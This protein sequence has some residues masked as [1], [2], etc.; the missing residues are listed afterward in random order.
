[1]SS[2]RDARP[3]EQ[4]DLTGRDR[5][6]WN[7]LTSWACQL[8]F[9]VSGFVMPRMLDRHVGQATLGV[10]DLAWVVV[11]YFS[12]AQIGIGSSVNRYVARFRASGDVEGL[13]CAVSSAAA[14][15]SAAA[16]VVM[17]L[18]IATAAGVRAAG[19]PPATEHTDF[20]A[21]VL[22]LGG[23]LA[24]QML[25]DAY[26]GVITGCHRWDLHNALN[27]ASY[28]LITV[29]ML[30]AL[31]SGGGLPHLAAVNFVGTILTEAVRVR[32][33]YRVCPELSVGLRSV[34]IVQARH[35]LLFGAKSSLVW[36]ARLILIQAS[37]VLV[38]T[39]LGPATL[40][41]YARPLALVRHIE[42]LGQKFAFVLTPTAS[43]LDGQ[44]DSE[45][46]RRLLMDTGRYSTY[47]TLPA[48]L[49]LGILGGPIVEV[50]MGSG[51]SNDVLMAVL[52]VG[53]F[54]PL[55]QQPAVTILMGM[56]RHGTTA[57]AALAAAAT[58]T[59]LTWAL[60]ARFG[61]G[62]VGAAAGVATTL[63]A[64]GIFV[65]AYA[66][67]VLNVR[68]ARLYARTLVEP[69]AATAPYAAVLVIM[70]IMFGTRPL[71]ALA[72]AAVAVPLVLAP[73]YWRRVL[74]SALRESIAAR[75]RS[76][77]ARRHSDRLHIC[78]VAHRAY[79]A[80]AQAKGAGIGGV[81]WQ[82]ALMSRWLAARGH[83][84]SVITWDE[85]QPHDM[86]IDGVRVVKVCSEQE[87]IAGLRFFHPRWTTLVRALRH[88]DA[89]VYYHNGAECV[90]GQ[91]ALWAKCHGRGFVFT[92]ASDMDCIGS[93]PELSRWRDKL[94]YRIGLRLADSIIVQT[95]TQQRMLRDAFGQIASVVPMPCPAPSVGA[96][97]N[98]PS[99][100]A[101]PQVLWLGRLCPVKRPDRLLEVARRCP[102]VWFD[103]VG[104]VRDPSFAAPILAAASKLP[105]V[106]MHG[107]V[108]R[109][110]AGTLMDAADLLCCTSDSEGFPNTFLEAWSRG[111]PIVS[112][113]DPDGL[114]RDVGLG[115]ACT[116]VEEL[117]RAI[118]RLVTDRACHRVISE[119][120]RQYFASTHA[121]ER[122]MPSFETS[123][124][125]AAHTARWADTSRGQQSAAA[126][127]GAPS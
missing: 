121:L 62:V 34:R 32:L 95:T 5:L 83:L 37:S 76:S 105:N 93:L 109:E 113:F 1:M 41:T 33:A 77:P 90:T 48:L 103:L 58:G 118:E 35:M 18:A 54:V 53:F 80:L 67:R 45:A 60:V 40:A 19:W 14:F 69:L 92:A 117:V 28:G 99:G 120:A 78:L 23:S 82:T 20:G 79:G 57:A 21:V 70:R 85:G 126:A 65:T 100:D 42:T 15:Q 38:A 73:V 102:G 84:I 51:Y 13:R 68:P 29:V 86:E 25:F 26:R 104:P 6:R 101:R 91:V 56:N 72:A 36:L 98:R 115:I 125:D 66:C 124:V 127:T 3:H 43:S 88:V 49:T 110:R 94:L 7:V 75:F 64:S 9:V 2:R 50:W 8:I 119:R 44:G 47:L 74:P 61:F 111:V 116:S 106:R 12:V 24:V 71:A 123:I 122:V 107:Q 112:T 10:W 17:T 22:L 97:Q 89:D 4:R 52:A 59:L 31:W 108:S 27:A 39:H 87:G 81:E 46:L 96:G 16:V 63:T 30:I 114:L 11:S 55:A